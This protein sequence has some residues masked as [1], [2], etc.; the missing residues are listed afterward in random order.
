L[1][2]HKEL[3]S[4]IQEHDIG[5]ATEEYSPDSRNLTITN[6]I[7]QYLLAGIAVV[8]SDTLGQKEVAEQ[9]PGSVFLFRNSDS[10]SLADVL[11]GLLSDKAALITARTKALEVAID[12]F[13][14]EKQE[15]LLVDWIKELI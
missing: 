15:K 4:R 13:C 3:L 7:L 11:N 10:Q 14:W 5:L 12:K 9:A 8:A 6:K 2:P 1:V